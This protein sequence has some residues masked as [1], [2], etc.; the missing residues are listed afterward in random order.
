[1]T[2]LQQPAFGPGEKAKAAALRG[3]Y[4]VYKLAKGSGRPLLPSAEFPHEQGTD[5]E[6]NESLYF[7]FTDP[8]TGLGG[9]TRIGVL[10]NQDSDIGVMMLFAG[11]RRLLV[12]NQAGRTD[13]GKG[14]KTGSLGY[15]RVIPL[16][17]WRLTF[18]GE[19]GDLADSRDLPDAAPEIIPRTPVQ[20]D[21][22]WEGIAPAFDF[23]N[24]DPAA[25]AEM[26]VSGGTRLSD[27]RSISKMGSE[28][29]EQAGRVTGTITIDGKETPFDGSGHRDHS[30]GIRD[31]SAPSSWTW[32][33]C[34]FSDEL[35]FNLSRVVIDSVDVYNG[36]LCYSGE[37]HP[38]RRAA[39]TT[40]FE[41]DGTTQKSLGFT[42]VDSSGR[43]VEVRGRVL[44]V[45]PLDLRARGHATWVNEGLAEYTWEGRKAYGIAEYLHQM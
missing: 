5:K 3:L 24:A 8:H 30:W 17:S 19:M 2:D 21:L 7:N 20:V 42:F 1:M 9:Y 10:P 31:W 15:E 33:T 16:R 22:T 12:T 43:L 25:I 32:L 38:V 4:A 13:T 11:G 6:W 28:H 26:L 18:D 36:F 41:A 14:F 23:K 29:Y 35:A 39:I 37:N 27:L 40:E 44:T 34:Q 45:I